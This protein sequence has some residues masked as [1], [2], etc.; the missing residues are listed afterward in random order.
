MC[1]M[2]Q[3]QYS[4]LGNILLSMLIHFLERF[5]KVSVIIK[6]IHP[7]EMLQTIPKLIK[8]NLSLNKHDS[9]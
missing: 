4:K 7:P 6:Y 3:W 2:E 8:Q 5:P 1:K 9:I